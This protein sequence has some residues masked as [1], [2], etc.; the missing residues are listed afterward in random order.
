MTRTWVGPSAEQ[1]L[2]IL[3]MAMS[4]YVS[5]GLLMRFSSVGSAPD[6]IFPTLHQ[7]AGDLVRATP[8]ALRPALVGGQLSKSLAA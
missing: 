6:Q 5:D 3:R 7:F 8:A 1:R 4:G 2:D